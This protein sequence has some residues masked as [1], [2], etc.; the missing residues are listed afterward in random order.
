MVFLWTLISE[1]GTGLL[2]L[3]QKQ[4]VEYGPSYRDDDPNQY[5]HVRVESI[6]KGRSVKICRDKESSH[7]QN[8]YWQDP[9][10]FEDY[11]ENKYDDE[12]DKKTGFPDK[13]CEVNPRDVIDDTF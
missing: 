13:S 12:R 8:E 5:C 6:V 10:P 11:R 1:P 7:N 3:T 9:F 4:N 2:I